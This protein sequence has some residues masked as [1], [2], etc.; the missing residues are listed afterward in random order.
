VFATTPHNAL[1]TVV[2][3]TYQ[4]VNWLTRCLD[5]L[6]EQSLA[7]AGRVACWVVDNASSDGTAELLAGRSDG[8]RVLRASRNLGFAGGNNLA[9]RE[10]TTPFAV[11]L[12]DD[13]AP[14]PGWLAELLGPFDDPKVAAVAA[15]LLLLNRYVAVPLPSGGDQVDVVCVLRDADDV[16]GAMIW[17][18]LL[19]APP[20]GAVHPCRPGADLL[21]PL[22]HSNDELTAPVEVVIEFADGLA[23]QVTVLPIGTATTD[24][25]N[26]AG[27]VLTRDGYAA[28]RGLGL[29]DSGRFDVPAEVFG[30]CGAA[31][32][33]RTAALLD[34]GLFDEEWFLYYEDVDLCWR[35]RRRGWTVRYAPGSV[36]RHQHSASVGTR[37]DLHLFHDHRNRLL[38]LVKNG[39]AG[40]VLRTVGRYPL[41]TASLGRRAMR[42]PR[43]EGR[44]AAIGHVRL[45]LRVL[46]SFLRL[47]P[48]VLTRRRSI[49]RAAEV[50]RRDLESW[51]GRDVLGPPSEPSNQERRILG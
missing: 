26:S 39:S 34:V 2:V 30:G 35:L 38:T 43:G 20:T 44:D 41:T 8:V 7:R 50:P 16:T 24:V 19:V 40:L 51:L 25:V 45:R 36:A 22:D 23:R 9:L 28:D 32:A 48:G 31:L 18:P 33:L 12:N 47:L 49:Q 15:K 1:V 13:A 42:L 27:T 10:V 14:Q 6:A 5:A 4:G 3:V 11:L 21:V 37:S 29:A 46:A 17:D